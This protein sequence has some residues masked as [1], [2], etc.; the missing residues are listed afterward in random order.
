MNCLIQ[1]LLRR[2]ILPS[3][4]FALGWAAS[5][6]ALIEKG[7]DSAHLWNMPLFC[8]VMLLAK[9]VAENMLKLIHL[10]LEHL[11]IVGWSK[12]EIWISSGKLYNFL[13]TT[14]TTSVT[15][16]FEVPS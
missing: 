9:M 15:F 2:Q 14:V 1:T 8:K 7:K 6:I 10:Y 3:S 13:V 4:K 12:L 5:N 16:T 11:L